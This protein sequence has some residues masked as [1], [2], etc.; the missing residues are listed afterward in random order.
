MKQAI[1]TITDD[2]EE[3][4][5]S[6]RRDFGIPPGIGVAVERALREHLNT[7]GYLDNSSDELK[8][9]NDLIIIPSAGGKPRGLKNAPVLDEE[10][11]VSRAVIEDR[12]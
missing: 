4:I 9:E 12:R 1:I 11:S 8:I 5:E 10:S 7:L 2:L 3:A 6:Y